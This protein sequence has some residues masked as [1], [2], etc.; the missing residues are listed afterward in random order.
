V[1]SHDRHFLDRL[2]TRVIELDKGTMKDWPGTLSEFLDRKAELAA[3]SEEAATVEAPT[4]SS[5]QKSKETKRAEAEIRNRYS[6][7]TRRL[8][9]KCS[10]CEGEITRL[11]ARQSE[12]EGMLADEKFYSDG[13]RAGAVVSE[14]NSIRE[15][16]PHVYEDWQEAEREL[17]ALE[18]NKNQELMNIT[19]SKVA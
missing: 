6:A 16:L 17:V 10:Q 7:L 9:E 8:K 18:D 11:E 5:T 1:V 15:R 4:G 12:I 19:G 2:V 13:A 14:Y 3:K